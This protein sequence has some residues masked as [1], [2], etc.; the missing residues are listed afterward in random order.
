MARG[1]YRHVSIGITAL[2]AGAI[3]ASLP[4]AGAAADVQ[5]LRGSALAGEQSA[6]AVVRGNTWYLRRT[7][8]TGAADVTFTYGLSTDHPLLGDWNGDGIATPGLFRNGSWLLRNQLSGGSAE[9]S[10]QF[11]APGDIP[12]IGDWDNDGD[13]DLGV[14]RGGRWY[15]DLGLTGGGAERSMAY[16][17]AADTPVAGDWN[18]TADARTADLP[19]IRRGSSWYLDTSATPD[20]RADRVFTFGTSTDRPVA[21]RWQAGPGIDQVGVVRNGTWYLR[22]SH[23]AGSGNASFN[24]GRA[25]DQFASWGG[26]AQSLS[27]PVRHYKYRIGTKGNIQNDMTVF[28]DLARTTLND[29]RGWSLGRLIRFSQTTGSDAHLRLWLATPAEVAAADPICDA[30]WSCRVGNDVYVNVKRYNEGTSTW[31][32]RPLSEYRQY[33][34][35]HEVGHWLGLGHVG[36]PGSGQAAPVMMQQSIDLGGCVINLWPRQS[37]KDKVYARHIG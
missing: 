31:S 9:V 4:A 8:G 12:V 22:Y 5:V 14:F 25:R 26:G 37:E 35:N 7:L 28:A 21:G 11:G 33:I 20:G 1:W 34:F 6:P 2:L 15:F 32:S 10:V 24:Y 27:Q 29:Q 19:G 18:G 36:C 17:Q 23:S 16:G 3:G 13:T 30:E